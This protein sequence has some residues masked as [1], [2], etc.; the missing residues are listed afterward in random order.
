LFAPDFYLELLKGAGVCDMKLAE[1]PPGDRI[2]YRVEKT[3]GCEYDHCAPANYL[4]MNQSE[5]LGGIGD[6]ALERFERLFARVNFAMSK[7]N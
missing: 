7:K 4:L 1:L 3:L 5:L 6:D 2:V